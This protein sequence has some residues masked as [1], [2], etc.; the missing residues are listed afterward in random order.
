MTRLFFLIAACGCIALTLN[1]ANAQTTNSSQLIQLQ[2]AEIKKLTTT[3]DQLRPLNADGLIAPV[4][5]QRAEQDLAAAKAKLE[6]IRAQSAAAEKLA[7]EQKKAAEAAKIKSFVKP[8]SMSL[9]STSAVLRST[10]GTWS[11]ANLSTVQ[12]FFLRTFGRALP[13]STIGQSATHNRM[14]WNH[15]HA[16]DVGLHPDSAEG[17][18]LIEYLQ[19]SGI[20]FLAFR[21]AVP[22]VST[23]PHIHIGTPSQRI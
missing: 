7:A 2:E 13:T 11:L 16:V 12:Q 19:S 5:L 4:E 9:S 6:E 23:G 18:A 3:V 1:L 17:R 22:G 8:T 10:T 14:G 21:K 15:R 20:P